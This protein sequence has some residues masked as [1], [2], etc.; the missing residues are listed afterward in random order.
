MKIKVYVL[1]TSICLVGCASRQPP[2]PTIIDNVGHKSASD[3]SSWPTLESNRAAIVVLAYHVFVSN[4]GT[5]S[6]IY[7]YYGEGLV[8]GKNTVIS[9]A[10]TRL[11]KP[12]KTLQS[13]TIQSVSDPV[14]GLPVWSGV[15]ATVVARL[16]V[17]FGIDLL[18]TTENLPKIRP[19][20]FSAA[21]SEEKV[22]GY[23]FASDDSIGWLNTQ[24]VVPVF[25]EAALDSRRCYV[26][27][28]LDDI[29]E[30]G[31]GFDTRHRLVCGF[32]VQSQV[33]ARFLQ[34]NG[35]AVVTK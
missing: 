12:P 2:P 34:D 17:G 33:L 29:G 6:G 25:V 23:R 20:V 31:E 32:F 21:S 30:G 26:I 4:A 22:E 5:G 16:D 35:V 11:I 3:D 24:R 7:T 19:V 1:F 15:P 9:S 14:T 13:I 18:T 10:N 27:D 28:Q 8:V